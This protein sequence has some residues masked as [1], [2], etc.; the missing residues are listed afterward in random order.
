[1]YSIQLLHYD[2][3]LFFGILIIIP[4]SHSSGIFSSFHIFF[5]RGF[6][7]STAISGSKFSTS[8][9]IL[10]GT[11]AFPFSNYVRASCISVFI[12]GSKFTSVSFSLLLS[13]KFLIFCLLSASLSFWLNMSEKYFCYLFNC[14][15]CVVK[16]IPDLVFTGI[17]ILNFL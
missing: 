4:S 14:S 12:V 10:S 9:F 3:S 2:M 6:S 5:N 1:M 16:S 8:G 11:A 13:L 15:S 17:F 7:S